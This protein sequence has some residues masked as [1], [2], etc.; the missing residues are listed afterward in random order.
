MDNTYKFKLSKDEVLVLKELLTKLKSREQTIQ[1]RLN[2]EI[3]GLA[4]N[5]LEELEHQEEF[6]KYDRW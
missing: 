6:Y 5:L 2:G 3:R 4:G 1:I